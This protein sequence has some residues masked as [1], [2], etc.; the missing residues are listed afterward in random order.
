M[1]SSV[2]D[3]HRSTI[4]SPSLAK[5]LHTTNIEPHKPTKTS[6]QPLP[7]VPIASAPISHHA[8]STSPLPPATQRL[9]PPAHPEPEL[10]SSYTCPICFSSPTN[11]TLT[12][13]GHICCG[14]CLFTAVKT[15]MQRT[16]LM[17][18]EQ[19]VARCVLLYV[20][21]ISYSPAFL[22]FLLDIKALDCLV[23]YTHSCFILLAPLHSTSTSY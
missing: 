8:P 16:A 13:C 4:T 19:A 20:I 11:A 5:I 2:L 7:N 15:T 23:N 22:F 14:S 17:M 9:L 10:L 12:P 3:Q 6:S 18:A 21:F 1:S